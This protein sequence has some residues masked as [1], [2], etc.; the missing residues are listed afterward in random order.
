MPKTVTMKVSESARR[1]LRMIAAHEGKALMAVV[2]EL[3]ARRLSEILAA[4]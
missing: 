2:E 1:N 3:A 4:K